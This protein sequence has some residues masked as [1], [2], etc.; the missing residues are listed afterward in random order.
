MIKRKITI[1]IFIFAV[2]FPGNETITENLAK[3]YD[4]GFKHTTTTATID[5]FHV[6]TTKW[7]RHKLYHELTVSCDA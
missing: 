1:R 4:S 2:T 3:S 5:N 6:T 7:N